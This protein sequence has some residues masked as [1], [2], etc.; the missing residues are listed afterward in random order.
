M[1]GIAPIVNPR[2]GNGFPG[3]TVTGS[4]VVV[5][6]G[7]EARVRTS[8]AAIACSLV[9]S[10][11]V[12]LCT[13]VS[14]ATGNAAAHPITVHGN[15]HT[16]DGAAT[17]TINTAFGS[18]VFVFDPD[19]GEWKSIVFARQDDDQVPVIYADDLPPGV[20]GPA[21]PAGPTGPAGPAGGTWNTLADVN[22]VTLPSQLLEADGTYTIGPWANVKKENSGGAGVDTT[23]IISGTGLLLTGSNLA[24]YPN[25]RTESL[26]FIPFAS[27]GLPATFG[28]GGQLRLLAVTTFAL[29]SGAINIGIDNDGELD[30]GGSPWW[31]AAGI[32]GNGTYNGLIPGVGSTTTSP[33]VANTMTLARVPIGLPEVALLN[34]GSGPPWSDAALQASKP[35]VSNSQVNTGTS[36]FALATPLIG[37]LGV[38]LAWFT[39][40]LAGQIN[41]SRLRI[42]Y[43]L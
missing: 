18:Q 14:D 28:P 40:G 23:Q 19:A 41:L 8:V 36:P 27:L 4:G 37:Q 30:P 13:A 7:A 32:N 29:P 11:S 31:T 38:V 16:I 26:L 10:P 3:V 6:E 34:I 5:P 17:A 42:D 43:R 9:P 15:G 35:L 20:P 33:L 22:F 2:T 25:P 12:V 21:G 24:N 1:S 39:Q